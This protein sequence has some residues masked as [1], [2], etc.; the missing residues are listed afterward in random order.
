MRASLRSV[1]GRG[2]ELGTILTATASGEQLEFPVEREHTHP[3]ISRSLKSVV[4]LYQNSPNS[5]TDQ[6]SRSAYFDE[7][8]ICE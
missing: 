3:E 5:D 7:E 1:Y 8:S 4:V 2:S 6:L